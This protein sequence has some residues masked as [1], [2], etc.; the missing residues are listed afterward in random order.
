MILWDCKYLE[1]NEGNLYYDGTT[2]RV[3]DNANDGDM[4]LTDHA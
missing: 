3:Y 2:I 4:C 1:S